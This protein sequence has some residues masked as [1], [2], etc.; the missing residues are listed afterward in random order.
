MAEFHHRPIAATQA[1]RQRHPI[2]LRSDKRLRELKLTRGSISWSNPHIVFAV[3]ITTIIDSLPFLWRRIGVPDRGTALKRCR[4]QE[5]QHVRDRVLTS[6]CAK[7]ELHVCFVPPVEATLGVAEQHI[8]RFKEA[9]TGKDLTC[10]EKIDRN[11]RFRPSRN[12]LGSV[13]YDVAID[14]LVLARCLLVG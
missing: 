9:K 12:F 11:R 13:R 1:D 3:S 4:C 2:A 6:C 14:L 5:V 7:R 8:G 10:V